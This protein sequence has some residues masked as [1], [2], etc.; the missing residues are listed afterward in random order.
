[1]RSF[2]VGGRDFFELWQ[3]DTNSA[4]RS[5]SLGDAHL[6]RR[7]DFAMEPVFW[8]FTLPDGQSGRAIGLKFTP[9]GA[10]EDDSR[11]PAA[12]NALLVVASVRSDLDR[13]LA[14]LRLVLAG[15]GLLSLAATALLVPRV[16]HR[17][18]LPLQRLADETAGIDAASLSARFLTNGLPGEL[19]PIASRLNELLARL[20]DS[21]ERERRFSSDVA[22]EFR[23]PVAELRSLAELSI[24]LPD[25][26]TANTDHEVL[27]IARHLESILTQLLALTRGEKG[28]LVVSRERVLLGPLVQQVCDRFREKADAR[29]LILNCHTQP[30]AAAD[31]DPALFRS[32]VTNLLEN[33]VE[34][35]PA[36]DTVDVG[37]SVANGC[38]Q[39][40][41]SNAAP[42]LSECDLPRLFDRFWRKDA[43]R[44][45]GTHTGLGLPLAQ[46]FARALGCELTA[47][48]AEPSRLALA[49]TQ[50]GRSCSH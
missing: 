3:T 39:L 4:E 11:K 7:Q 12:P 28:P 14:V 35:A 43:A 8:N 15:G 10:D 17:E 20:E 41:V 46:T 32:I 16:L 18:L 25:T 37:L 2:D 50:N 26:R 22:H 23:T 19:A 6:P 42:D 40:Q 24:K 31:T 30:D 49:L 1:M 21:F 48:F 9:E 44:A 27:A 36:G 47:S 45:A 38:L 33:A 34:Y 13:T 29:Q 5:P